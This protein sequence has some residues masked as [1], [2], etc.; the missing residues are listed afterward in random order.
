MLQ[1]VINALHRKAP[2][3][4]A[5][6]RSLVDA[7]PGSADAHHLLGIALRDAGDSAA[8]RVSFD[9]A[10]ELAP[11][12]ATYHFSRALLARADGDLEGANTASARALALDPNRF[13]AY[14]LRI[15]LALANRDFAEAER[16]I[17]LAE[18]A[19][20]NHPQL[21][22]VA[23]QVALLK[24]DA[25]R[26]IKLLNKAAV[27]QPRIA[28]IF[29]TLGAAYQSRGRSAFAEQSLRRAMALDPGET[30]W[31]RLLV[32]TLI[33]QG[34]ADLAEG[35]LTIYRQQHPQDPL[36]IVLQAELRM[37]VGRTVEALNDFRAALTL[38]PRNM[39]ALRGLQTTL[40]AVADRAQAR[41]AWEAILQD[42]TGLDP[43]WAS[44]LFAAE[45]EDDYDEVLRRW[46][47]ALP[48]SVAAQ[49]YQ[50]RRDEHL[51]R[52]AEAGAGFDAVL[53]RVPLQLD[54]LAGKVVIA[55]RND[56][57]AS[58]E[59]LNALIEHS[60][61]LQ[62]MSALANR[63]QAH[64]RLQQPQLAIAD[65][66]QAQSKFGTPLVDVPMP[67][68]ASTGLVV[69]LP[70]YSRDTQVV[71]LWGPPG[72]GSERVAAALRGARGR[73][74]LQAAP[75]ARPRT[76]QYPEAF[77]D[78]AL[79]PFELAGVVSELAPV[80]A[81]MLEPHQALGHHGVFD[82]LGQWDARVVPALRH[83]LA[84]TRLIAVLRDPRDMLLNWLAFGTPASVKFGDANESAAWLV[85]QLEHLL[86]GRDALQLPV[87]VVDMDR[88][89][90]DARVVMQEIAT[91]AD[92]A[93]PPDPQPA[94]Q[95]LVDQRRVP[96]QLPAGR[97]RVYREVLGEAFALLAPVAERLGYPRD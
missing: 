13:D 81:R 86:F 72:S 17:T 69:G 50:A 10:I 59:P 35:E 30:R 97:W 90:A 49:L 40:A 18:R 89:D 22:F 9:R 3:A 20:P 58:I 63:G 7:A 19:D 53:A 68:E 4:V 88:F 74:M 77:I 36:G 76:P 31:R 21:L 85:R 92:L 70:P 93:T 75:D 54:A 15:Q 26:A 96:T 14:L 8:A 2:N 25:E 23:G 28:Q 66:L 71:M 16:Q 79:H 6:A 45:A 95:L 24:G 51:G 78:R 67:P 48:E 46:R 87:L 91:F 1:D 44:R 57:A 60:P 55:L 47:E 33:S 11:E 42:D 29:A 84:G 41:A 43:V 56:P 62:A 27:E 37:G 83:A 38:A 39:R 94:L 65:W 52:D 5:M 82:W 80:Y 12:E 73:P 61:Q 34:Q 32:E 64:D